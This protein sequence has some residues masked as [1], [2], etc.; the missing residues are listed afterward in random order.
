[1]TFPKHYFS[2]PVIIQLAIIISVLFFMGWNQI[3]AN[4]QNQQDKANTSK[5]RPIVINAKGLPALSNP[6]L[7]IDKSDHILNIYDNE[8]LIAQFPAST[9]AN[10]GDKTREGDKK[11]PEGTFYICFKNPKSKFVLSMGLS[12]PNIEDAKRGLK[13]GLISQ[14]DYKGIV[15]AI[16]KNEIPPWY[17]KLGGEIMIHGKRNGGRG[18]LGCIAL[19]DDVITALYGKIPIGTVV[20]IQK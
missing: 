8:Q 11:T 12:Y 4:N 15:S 2:W 14:K 5:K 9:G 18:T 17:T 19:E 10:I 6:V 3:S 1:M 16:N 20:T 13:A 7:I